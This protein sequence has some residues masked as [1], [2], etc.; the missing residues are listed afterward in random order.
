[1]PSLHASTTGCCLKSKNQ[2]PSAERHKVDALE[3]KVDGRNLGRKKK[4]KQK[5]TK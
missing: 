5:T 3:F 2:K 1:M 4:T